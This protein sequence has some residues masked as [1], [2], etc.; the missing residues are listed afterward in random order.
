MHGRFL[1]VSSVSVKS[2]FQIEKKIKEL[3]LSLQ[4]SGLHFF[5]WAMDHTS[6]TMGN[7]VVLLSHLKSAPSLK[8]LD[9]A[10]TSLT[11]GG[12]ED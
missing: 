8:V 5:L 3:T 9:T 6:V 11:L 7:V 1:P 2:V 12:V 4:K 10:G